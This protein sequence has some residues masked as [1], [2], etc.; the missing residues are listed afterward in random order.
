M[1]QQKTVSLF[2]PCIVD[3]VY[4]EIG[5]AMARVLEF[6]GYK[7]SYDARQTCCGQPGYN[8]I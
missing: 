6:L 4:P 3:Q 8:G 2:I 7:I 5:L 1:P